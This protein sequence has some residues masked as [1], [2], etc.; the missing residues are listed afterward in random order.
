MVKHVV[1]IRTIKYSSKGILKGNPW[2]PYVN[3]AVPPKNPSNNP[4]ILMYFFRGAVRP[5]KVLDVDVAV[6]KM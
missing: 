1:D 5:S 4:H 2:D 6:I 3:H